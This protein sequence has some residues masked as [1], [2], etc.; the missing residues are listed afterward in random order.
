MRRRKHAY[1]F[2]IEVETSDAPT[3]KT[4]HQSGESTTETEGDD[5]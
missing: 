2:G 1:D 5:A 3:P 4:D